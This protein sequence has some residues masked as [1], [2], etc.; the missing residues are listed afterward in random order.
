MYILY[1]SYDECRRI[2]NE[3]DA[4]KVASVEKTKPAKIN[5]ALSAV[6]K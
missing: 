5:S 1:P 2:F 3:N 4:V 6:N